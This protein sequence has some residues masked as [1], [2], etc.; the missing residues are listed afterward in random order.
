MDFTINHKSVRAGQPRAKINTQH[1]TLLAKLDNRP[2]VELQV[3]GTSLM[4]SAS[5]LDAGVQCDVLYNLVPLPRHSLS[6]IVVY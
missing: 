2:T 5:N 1:L 4:P 3:L 6:S